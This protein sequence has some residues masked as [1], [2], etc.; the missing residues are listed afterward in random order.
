MINASSF[1]IYLTAQRFSAN[2][3]TPRVGWVEIAVHYTTTCP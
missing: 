1:G 2:S 3:D